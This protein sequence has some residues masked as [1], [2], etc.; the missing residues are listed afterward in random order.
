MQITEKTFSLIPDNI[1]ANSS[2]QH[3]GIASKKSKSKKEKIPKLCLAQ[4]HEREVVVLFNLGEIN[5]LTVWFYVSVLPLPMVADFLMHCSLHPMVILLH[6]Q[7]CIVCQWVCVWSC[8]CLLKWQS[9]V[10]QSCLVCERDNRRV[11]ALGW[12]AANSVFIRLN[13][14]LPSPDS[15]CFSCCHWWADC[16]CGSLYAFSYLFL[17][18]KSQ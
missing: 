8:E 3:R 16:K 2:I 7:V 11:Y 4:Y 15:L 6:P 18:N 17:L 10:V 13:K 14:L 5:I 1:W 9:Y 12:V